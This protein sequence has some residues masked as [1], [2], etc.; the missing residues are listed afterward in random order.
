MVSDDDFKTCKTTTFKQPDETSYG[1]SFIPI[2]DT[3]GAINNC[4]GF[5]PFRS[6]YTIDI[7]DL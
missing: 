6:T 3:K 4:H 7:V 1:T 5:K 2:S